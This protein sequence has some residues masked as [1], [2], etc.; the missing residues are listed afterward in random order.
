M[1]PNSEFTCKSKSAF[2]VKSYVSL[3]KLLELLAFEEWEVKEIPAEEA[4][5][6]E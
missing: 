5:A 6:S 2:T 1:I 4:S 3:K